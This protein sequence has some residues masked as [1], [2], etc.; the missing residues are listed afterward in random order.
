[1]ISTTNNK[2]GINHD[3]T[4]LHTPGDWLIEEKCG[5][6]GSWTPVRVFAE[7]QWDG[8]GQMAPM[9]PESRASVD[10]RLRHT[11]FALA[12]TDSEGYRLRNVRTGRIEE[13]VAGQ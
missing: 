7:D 11:V 3:T 5:G 4:A 2:V 1:M 6:C 12:M 9:T 8:Q 13:A 10:A